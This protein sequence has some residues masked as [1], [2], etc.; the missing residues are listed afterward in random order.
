VDPERQ[1]L[2]QRRKAA[3]LTHGSRTDLLVPERSTAVRP[4]TGDAEPPPSARPNVASAAPASM[5]Q[6]TEL[7]TE[8]QADATHA[9]A[10]NVDA[11]IQALQPEVKPSRSMFE[12]LTRLW[13]AAESVL[14]EP[15]QVQDPY[16]PSPATT[17]ARS[18][19]LKRFPA[20]GLVAAA[21]AGGAA[22][23]LWAPPHSV[24]VPPDAVGTPARTAPVAAIPAPDPDSDNSSHAKDP[25]GAV[26]SAPATEPDK[27]V[28][29]ATSSP[30]DTVPSPPDIQSE[31]RTTI[32]HKPAAPTV[33]APSSTRPTP[34][35][36]YDA[37]A[38]AAGFNRNDQ[39]W[40]RFRSEPPPH[41]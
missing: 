23:V 21:L 10:A 36:A 3:A 27:P 1:R 15:T 35:E 41:R 8:S 7:F 32:G 16:R 11:P 2:S 30:T 19:R 14:P 4:E 25:M 33:T 5:R 28:D 38:R 13:R 17:P 37:W 20:A 22:S 34:A 31:H 29:N 39:R 9:P 12:V 18:R 6:L 40:E 24:S 26:R